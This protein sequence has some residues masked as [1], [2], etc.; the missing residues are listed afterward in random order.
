MS[1][2]HNV[3]EIWHKSSDGPL[4]VQERRD[5]FCTVWND[6][7]T[8]IKD[9]KQMKKKWPACDLVVLEIT[10]KGWASTDKKKIFDTSEQSI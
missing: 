3:Y 8:A 2:P 4:T 10:I 9:A 7:E 1:F 6:S 5:I